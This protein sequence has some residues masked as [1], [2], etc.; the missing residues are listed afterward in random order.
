[1]GHPEQSGGQTV[2]EE[3]AVAVQSSNQAPVPLACQARGLD[4]AALAWAMHLSQLHA[5][6][7][8][9]QQGNKVAQG[10]IGTG[11]PTEEK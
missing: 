2:A 4:D 6:V 8:L 7:E 3:G 11:P 1:M 10:G 5:H 9:A